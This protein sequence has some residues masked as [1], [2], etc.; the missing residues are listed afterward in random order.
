MSKCFTAI[1]TTLLAFWIILISTILY[2]DNTGFELGTVEVLKTAIEKRTRWYD[3]YSGT[4]KIGYAHTT[5]EKVLDELIITDK[6]YMES[7]G[8]AGGNNMTEIL[9][10]I[11]DLAFSVKSFEYSTAFQNGKKVRITGSVEPDNITFFIETPE[12]NRVHT[13]PADGKTIYFPSTVLPSLLKKL[14]SEGAVFSVRVIDLINLST[15]NYILRLAEIRPI[16][17]GIKSLSLYKFTSANSEWWTTE[18]GNI[19]K[20][21]WMAGLTLYSQPENIAKDISSRMLFDYTGLPAVKSDRLFDN[22]DKIDWARIRI[23]GVRLTPELYD[24]TLITLKDDTLTIRREIKEDIRKRTYKLPYSGS[25]HTPHLSHDDWVSS[26]YKP[27]RDTGLSY[28]RSNGHDAAALTE[29]LTSYIYTLVKP[30]PRFVL[31]NAEDVLDTGLGGDY[32][33][34]AVMFPSYARAAGLPTRL[35]GGVVYLNGFFY[36]HTWVEV[37]FDRWV[38]VDPTFYQFPADALHIPLRTGTL[39]DIAS[40]ADDLKSLRIEVLEAK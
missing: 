7:G 25:E 35:I 31:L 24:D 38:P 32:L 40:I 22:P 5:H 19:V 27:L 9:K 20:E 14:P 28:A 3:I 17:I 16:K 39:R 36:Y 23:K 18:D 13:I 34:R 15:K 33:A 21:K 10:I 11:S 4:D 30:D 29:Y 2:K 37:W 6:R 12:K 1:N 8:P 26:D